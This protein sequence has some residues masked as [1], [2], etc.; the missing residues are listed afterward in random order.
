M[1][2]ELRERLSMRCPTSGDAARTPLLRFWGG[3]PSSV[4]VSV[5]VYACE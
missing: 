5:R 1:Q 4:E 2:V 3:L